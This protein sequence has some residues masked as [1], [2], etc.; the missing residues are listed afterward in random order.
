ML[1]VGKA[2]TVDQWAW[3]P[4]V[5]VES[6]QVAAAEPEEHLAAALTVGLATQAEVQ[7]LAEVAAEDPDLG[8][9]IVAPAAS[10]L[11]AALV[12]FGSVV[13]GYD[14]VLQ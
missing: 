11:A 1:A 5:A 7:L 9:Q 3:G 13:L 10:M 4:W 8:A 14:R 6:E 2:A 12:V